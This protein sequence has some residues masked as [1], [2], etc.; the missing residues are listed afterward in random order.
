M[1]FRQRKLW[2]ALTILIIGMALAVIWHGTQQLL[3]RPYPYNTFLFAPN[4]SYSDF[5]DFMKPEMPLGNYFPSAYLLF[6]PF[7]LLPPWV[8]PG[9]LSKG[10]LQ[11]SVFSCC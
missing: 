2:L 5:T 6:A 10:C 11:C 9:D 8:F 3:G 4:S 7:R 1:P